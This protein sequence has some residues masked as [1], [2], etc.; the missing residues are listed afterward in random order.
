MARAQYACDCGW[1]FLADDQA[2]AISCPKCKMRI[3]GADSREMR[4]AVTNRVKF[5]KHVC[6][7][8]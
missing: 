3:R 1:S 4:E 2:S 5:L 6:D 8:R 7:K